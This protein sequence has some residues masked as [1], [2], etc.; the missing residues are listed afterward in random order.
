MPPPPE[1]VAPAAPGNALFSGEPLTTSSALVIFALDAGASRSAGWLLASSVSGWLSV[2]PRIAAA[3]NA[4][5]PCVKK[6][7]VNVVDVGSTAMV[8]LP[9]IVPPVSPEPAVIEV[10][11]PPLS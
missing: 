1:I 7:P 11:V 4:F 6:F 2:V 5:P 10:T 3:P 8:P 9:V